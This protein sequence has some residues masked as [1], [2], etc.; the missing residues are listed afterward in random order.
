MPGDPTRLD[1][2]YRKIGTRGFVRTLERFA[3]A[4]RLRV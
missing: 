4:V 1:Y 3:S 2:G